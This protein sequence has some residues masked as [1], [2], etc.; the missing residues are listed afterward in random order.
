MERNGY[1]ERHQRRELGLHFRRDSVGGP[2]AL[3]RGSVA[4]PLRFRWATRT[5]RRG[6]PA[7]VIQLSPALR[8]TIR[9]AVLR[10]NPRSLSCS[11]STTNT[12]RRSMNRQRN[13]HGGAT[14]PRRS[15]DENAGRAQAPT[16]PNRIGVSIALHAYPL[17]FAAVADRDWERSLQTPASVQ[18]N[19]AD[20]RAGRV[21]VS[22]R[23]RK[24]RA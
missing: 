7:D 24:Q 21:H 13:R 8:C 18:K 12:P 16:R 10:A 14:D 1:G 22:W 23:R 17:A 2:S 3:R 20:A 9:A 15:A 6:G 5:L 4:P 19:L 11:S